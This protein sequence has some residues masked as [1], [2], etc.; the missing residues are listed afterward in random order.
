V[1]LLANRRL[2]RKVNAIDAGTRA[3]YLIASDVTCPIVDPLPGPLPRRPTLRALGRFSQPDGQLSRC[4][5]NTPVRPA[6]GVSGNGC[7]RSHLPIL[8]TENT[9]ARHYSVRARP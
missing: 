6:R 5:T 7:S 8:D 2:R 1:E 3:V 9:G 4:P